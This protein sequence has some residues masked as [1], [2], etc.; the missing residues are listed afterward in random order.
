LKTIKT[1]GFRRKTKMA[2]AIKL[3]I[4][5]ADKVANLAL[6]S[7]SSNDMDRVISLL[8]ALFNIPL[9]GNFQE[10][11]QKDATP[12]KAVLHPTVETF[13]HAAVTSHLTPKDEPEFYKTGIKVD[14]DGTKRYKCRYTCECGKKGNHYIPLK[15]VDVT[16][17]ECDYLL[18]VSLAT[19]KVDALGI[20]VR[21]KNGNFFI[22]GLEI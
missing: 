14:E 15:T 20:P 1:N 11:K 5:S 18:D 2:F 4:Q 6:N 9:K 13:A 16:C 19:G 3:K 8:S 22:A 10:V 7:A 12:L 21:D 17:H